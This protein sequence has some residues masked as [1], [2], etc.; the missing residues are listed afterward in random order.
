LT[1]YVNSVLPGK[2]GPITAIREFIILPSIRER[3]VPLKGIFGE[4]SI[5][6]NTISKRR[7]HRQQDTLRQKETKGGTLAKEGKGSSASGGATDF[8]G[9]EKKPC[10]K[11]KV[12]NDVE[13]TVFRRCKGPPRGQALYRENVQKTVYEKSAEEG[14]QKPQKKS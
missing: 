11:R 6:G 5:T 12:L 10:R 7:E 3:Y 4:E 2:V 9:G 14:R 1:V 8:R 13:R